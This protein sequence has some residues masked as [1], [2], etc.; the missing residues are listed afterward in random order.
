MRYRIVLFMV[1][2]VLC[3]PARNFAQPGQTAS[4]TT[5]QRED[6]CKPSKVHVQIKLKTGETINGDAIEIDQ[7]EVKL[8]REGIVQTIPSANIKEI[9]S[10]QTTGQ[11]LRHIARVLGYVFAALLAYITIRISQGQ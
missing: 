9:Q 10:R 7:S 11:R 4:Q 1:L 2:L 5:S 8:C 6:F 3:L